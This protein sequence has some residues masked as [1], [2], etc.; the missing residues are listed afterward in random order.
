M[1][2]FAV[3]H[4]RTALE[5]GAP[6]CSILARRRGTVCPQ[7]IDWT[8]FIRPVGHNF[9]KADQGSA[10][11]QSAWR[12]MYAASGAKTPDCW[13]ERPPIIK[14]DGH[15]ISTSDIFF[16]AHYLVRCLRRTTTVQPFIVLRYLSTLLIHNARVPWMLLCASQEML[17]T[18]V[19]EVDYITT[20]GIM[21]KDW[22][23]MPTTKMLCGNIIK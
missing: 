18:F 19:G 17:D 13:R 3:E 2:A 1:G 9:M 5:R 21:T 11:V 4:V 15:T 14:P 23:E 12:N 20:D 8:D 7:V 22:G 6:H 16:V 10:M